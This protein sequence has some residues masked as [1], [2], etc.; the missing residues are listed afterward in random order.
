MGSTRRLVP[1]AIGYG[2]PF[3]GAKTSI[4]VERVERSLEGRLIRSGAQ[5]P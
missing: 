2:I 3:S 5:Q 4:G 1:E